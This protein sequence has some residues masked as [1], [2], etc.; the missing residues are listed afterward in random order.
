[1]SQLG[2]GCGSKPD[3]VDT[4]LVQGCGRSSQCRA[5][6]DDIVDDQHRQAVPRTPRPERWTNEAVGSRF[7]SLWR[8]VG[9]IQQAT[10]GNSQLASN[11]LGDRLGLVVAA[12]TD[13]AGAGRRPC[14][15]VDIVE[16]QAVDHVGGQDA[17]R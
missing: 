7:S 9:P 6:G 12:S 13:P 8:T 11:G 4:C 1:M 3:V 10:A 14:D 15:H 17:R 16:A 2:A 5:G